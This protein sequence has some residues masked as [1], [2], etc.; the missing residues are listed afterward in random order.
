MVLDYM[1]TIGETSFGSKYFQNFMEMNLYGSINGAT[2]RIGDDMI[3]QLK[4][5][6]CSM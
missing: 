2:M 5:L 4:N 3:Y 6:K 1:G